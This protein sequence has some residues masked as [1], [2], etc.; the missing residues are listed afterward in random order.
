MNAGAMW[1]FVPLLIGLFGVQQPGMFSQ[2]VTRLIIHDE[3]V[4][5]VPVQP[6]AYAP[7]IE[8][9]ERKGP[10]CIPAAS[11]ERVMLSGPEQVDFVLANHDRV[12]AQFDEDCQALDFY[13]GIYLQLQDDR[14]CAKRDAVHSRIGGSCSID[15]FKLIVPKF[16]R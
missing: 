11:I 9:I 13:G 15:R 8:W 4:L 6:R 12:R 16:R 14:L 10:S 1:N 5:R 7:E 3:V 2:T